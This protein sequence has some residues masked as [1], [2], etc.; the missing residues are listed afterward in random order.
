MIDTHVHVWQLGR[1]G[2]RWPTAAELRL[3]RDFDLDEFWETALP[4]GMTAAILVQSQESAADT[5]WLLGLAEQ[6]DRVA[7]VIGW[8]DLAAP[9]ASRRIQALA[10][11]RKLA[12]M[13]PMVQDRPADWYDDPDLA[14]G[15]AALADADLCLEALVRE[16]H[17]PALARLAARLPIRIVVDHAA[18]PRIDE[19]DGFAAWR[20]AIAPLADQR[21]VAVKLSGLLSECGSAGA[22]AIPPYV[23]ALI[24]LFGTDR[25]IWGSDWPVLNAVSTYAGWQALARQLVPACAQAAVFG[26]NAGR[27]YRL[28]AEM[29]A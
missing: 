11:H 29:L 3:Y 15:L 2:C 7:A 20:A 4:L 23:E 17:L 19:A 16:R 18:K 1:N 26:G 12:G 25:I 6:E 8:S 21:H 5:E 13:R 28:T 24:A 22:D 27:I 9:G 10:L 14:P